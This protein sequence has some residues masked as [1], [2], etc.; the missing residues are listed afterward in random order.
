MELKRW[1]IFTSTSKLSDL[2]QHAIEDMNSLE[3][4]MYTA[5]YRDGNNPY[6]PYDFSPIEVCLSGAVMAVTYDCQRLA[7]SK[8]HDMHEFGTLGEI[9]MSAIELASSGQYRH[10][11]RY[12][13]LGDM[14]KPLAA[15]WEHALT[16]FEEGDRCNEYYEFQGWGEWDLHSKYL[17]LNIERLRKHGENYQWQMEL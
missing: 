9:R 6:Q 12:L 15:H 8:S 11:M 5:I 16:E 1:E 3:R 2:L 17:E 7:Y 13:R 10:A 4:R 14:H